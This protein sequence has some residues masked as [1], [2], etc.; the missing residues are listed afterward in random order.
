MLVNLFLFLSHSFS[1]E[2]LKFQVWLNSVDL[3]LSNELFILAGSLAG[4]MLANFIFLF[5]SH[6]F[7]LGEIKFQVWLNSVELKLSY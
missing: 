3:Q 1:L 2:E 5:L 6:S 7:G 4:S